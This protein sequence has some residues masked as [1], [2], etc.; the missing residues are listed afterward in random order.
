MADFIPTIMLPVAF[1]SGAV[2]LAT[3]LRWL[4]QY[5]EGAYW[6]GPVRESQRITLPKEGA[7]TL[8]YDAGRLFTFRRPFWR[9]A[10]YRFFL[11]DTEGVYHEIANPARFAPPTRISGTE[12]Y[13]VAHFTVP[14]AGEYVLTIE[15]FEP[16]HAL[17]ESTF[18]LS[19]KVSYAGILAH[20]AGIFAGAVMVLGSTL[21][22]LSAA[23]PA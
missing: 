5:V 8:E 4:R 15:G 16:G 3:Q 6:Q 22:V 23:R 10:G 14:K 13:Q 21:A 12:R 17:E 7:V 1:C 19:P 11:S 20:M 9:K 18:L 2:L